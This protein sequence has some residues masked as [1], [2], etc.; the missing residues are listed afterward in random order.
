MTVAHIEH[1]DCGKTLLRWSEAAL[2]TD[3]CFLG[4]RM[5]RFTRMSAASLQKGHR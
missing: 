2:T 5:R 1:G 3:L 4:I